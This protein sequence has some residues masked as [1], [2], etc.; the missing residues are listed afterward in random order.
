MSLATDAR[1]TRSE[2]TRLVRAADP[3]ALL[4][5]MR[6]MRRV[7]KHDQQ[8]EGLI[9]NIPHRKTYLIDRDALLRLVDRDELYLEPNEPLPPRIL[10]VQRPHAERLASM[11]LR[12]ALLRH[13]RLLFHIK[14]HAVLEDVLP[15]GQL[16]GAELR[17]RIDEIGQVEFDEIRDVLRQENML[18]DGGN[19]RAVYIEFAATYLEL[20]Y[21]AEPMLAKYFPSLADRQRIDRILGDLVDAGRL[22]RQTRLAGAPDPEFASDDSSGDDSEIEP[23][24]EELF[25]NYEPR[26]GR[27]YQ[28]MLARAERVLAKGNVVRAAIL[29]KRAALDAPP[30]IAKQSRAQA[31]ENIDQLAVRL[32]VAVELSDE[33][34]S[35][36]RRHLRA[37]LTQTPRGMWTHEARILYDLQKACVDHE[38]EIYTADLVEWTLSLGKRDIRRPLPSQREVLMCQHLRRAARR[39]RLTRISSNQ[40]ER[41]TRLLNSAV[42][43]AE[44]NLRRRLRPKIEAALDKVGLDAANL[45][46]EIARHKLIEELLDRI[47]ERGFLKIGDLRDALSRNQL[48][49]PMRSLPRSLVQTDK[50]LRTDWELAKSLDGVY[51]RGEFYMRWLQSMSAIMFG[52]A[53][54][55]WLTLYLVLPFGGAFVALF[56]FNAM[57]YEVKHLAG[58]HADYHALEETL[59]PLQSTATMPTFP[60]G[61]PPGV[62]AMDLTLG[63][64]E[65]SPWQA[66]LH[67]YAKEALKEPVPMPP[68]WL[69]FGFGLFLLGLIHSPQFRRLTGRAIRL[70]FKTFWKIVYTWPRRLL[71]SQVV[72]RIRASYAYRLVMRFLLRPALFTAFTAPLLSLLSRHWEATWTNLGIVFLF[73]SIL[74]NT[75]LGRDVEE[76]VTDWTERAWHSFRIRVL[77]EIYRVIMQFFNQVLEALDQLLYTVDEL[78][79]FRGGESQ[80][81]I[82]AKAVL[83]VGW[84]LVTYVVRFAVNLL[85]EPQI[86]PIKHFPVVTVAHKLLLPTIP[87]FALF[88]QN[89][90]NY[91]QASSITIAT[92][93]IFA[94]PGIFGFLV[95]ELKENWRLF[96]ANRPPVLKPDL[97]GHHGETMT[98][99]L[100]PGF[101]SGTL[102]KLYRRLRR[103]ERKAQHTR[104]W[105]TSRKH[106]EA[107]VEVKHLI[108]HFADRQLLELLRRSHAWGGLRLELGA[109]QAGSNNV[110]ISI[111]CPQLGP[112]DLCLAFQE[113]T[114]F[115]MACIADPGWLPQLSQRQRS[116]FRSALAGFYKLAG[117]QLVREQIRSCFDPITMRYDVDPRGLVIWPDLGYQD[118]VVYSLGDEPIFKPQPASA[119]KMPKLHREQLLY[120]ETTITW[121]EWLAAWR[122]GQQAGGQVG[123]VAPGMRLLPSED[124]EPVRANAVEYDGQPLP[125]YSGRIPGAARNV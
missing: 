92:A 85:I 17:R 71:T 27:G 99:F 46:E 8:I 9:L 112:R 37:L 38:R 15:E 113:Q 118:E 12:Q 78:L 51:R 45:P 55:R 82:A 28:K 20:R 1:I 64:S 59:A 41:L 73:W 6:I 95:W 106:R 23:S 35:G 53:L 125:A 110:Q 16:A 88:L 103:A 81:V 5:P 79:R 93:V 33:E 25:S 122:R 4:V 29:R 57:V 66:A 13:W 80:A 63:A 109:V 42:K 62:L 115:L 121:R 90:L 60:S 89:T 75:R 49:L 22:Y 43:R 98:R 68:A 26:P 74:L 111:H 96:K 21:F 107:I 47:A 100:R 70:F 61:A 77:A 31:R 36:W 117:A 18:L 76:R 86:N 2:L 102:P 87:S 52:T 97:I 101:H 114:G 67:A 3:S 32:Q 40:R 7:I 19:D 116:A 24:S 104:N 11:P 10:L 56:G 34:M 65:D 48:K 58:H 108:G 54:G 123:Q 44:S 83:G 120:S 14:V 69:M 84:F 39:M 91:D 50:L 105:K 119:G 72:Q 94:I 124:R 30:E